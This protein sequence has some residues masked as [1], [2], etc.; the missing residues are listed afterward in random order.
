VAH[1]LQRPQAALFAPGK[2]V[3]KMHRAIKTLLL[4]AA[5]AVVLAPAQARAEGY[6]APWAGVNWGNDID[7]GRAVVGVTAGGM[8]VG[9]IVG[10]E[11]DFG[12][13]PSF[14]GTKNEFG[15]N[16]VLTA[17]G[18]LIVGLPLGGTVGRGIRPFVTGGVGLLRTQI[19]GGDVFSP[20][21][22]D[23]DVA[24]NAGAGVMG[25]LSDHVGLR[26]DV[27]YIRNMGDDV[28]GIGDIHFWRLGF[29]VTFR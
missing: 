15:S 24:W 11:F 5:V 10:G 12:F 29:G 21:V 17:M 26:G 25:Y 1:R 28:S 9:G 2:G 14:F 20:E 27:R 4:L 3:V 6:F 16:S 7:H 18:N 13:S 19:D 23:N 8:G 22:D